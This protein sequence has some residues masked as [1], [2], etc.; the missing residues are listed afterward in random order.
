M[1]TKPDF[2]AGWLEPESAANTENQPLYRYNHTMETP[3]GHLFEM[4][5]TPDR[6]RIRITH[7]ANTFIEIHP[8]GDGTFKIFG[9]GY[10]ITLGDYNVAVGV[11]D[12]KNAHKMNITVYG[13]V[14]MRVTGDKV[15]TIEGNYEQHIK[16]HYKQIIEKTSTMQSMGDMIIGGGYSTGGTVTIQTGDA[17]MLDAD[18]AINGELTAQKI[19]SRTRVDAV[20]G[21]SA[22]PLGFVT[23]EGGV[24]VGVPVAVPTKVIVATD[25][26]A[27][28][29]VTAG[30]SVAAPMG[31]FGTM[32]AMLMTDEINTMIFDSHN[33]IAPLGPTSTPLSSMV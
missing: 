2:Y 30:V 28:S 22:G 14:N 19:T 15:E 12:G 20:S 23:T 1:T 5:D 7:R 17:L 25:V 26:L 9:D 27:G 32:D 31:T 10:H 4:D 6:E 21:M 33:H 29:M 8:N 3:R 11:D 24:A 13:D 18:L 16:G